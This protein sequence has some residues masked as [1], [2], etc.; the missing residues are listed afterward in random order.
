[1]TPVAGDVTR[2]SRVRLWDS[3]S[4]FTTLVERNAR[5]VFA[6]KSYVIL[7][8]VLPLVLALTGLLVGGAEGLGLADGSPLNTGARFILT[9]FVLGAVFTGASTSIQ[10][11]VKD[12]VIYQRER[13]VGLSRHAY[14]LAKV[15]VLGAIAAIQGLVFATFSLIGRPGPV[16]PVLLPW[17]GSVIVSVMIATVVSCML[18]LMLSTLLPTRDAALPTLVIV[19]MVQVVL[20]GAIPLRF[21]QLLDVI[22]PVVPGYWLFESM[23]SAID[24]SLLL[25]DPQSSSWAASPGNV[26]LGWGVMV[27]TGVTFVIA[28]L[29]LAGRHD[30]GRK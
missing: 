17:S 18:G 2:S 4:Q 29:F 11:L 9:I 1:M 20:S 8:A 7:L 25:G 19:T 26:L 16:D 22:G 3:I 21:E 27:L 30:P 14:V 15:V 28:A 23:A 10:E 5:V 24:L 12:R 13:A 6:D